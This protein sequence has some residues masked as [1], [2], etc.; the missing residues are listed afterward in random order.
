MGE[1][2]VSDFVDPLEGVVD[3]YAAKLRVNNARF[4]VDDIWIL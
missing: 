4:F 2:L 3:V 1:W